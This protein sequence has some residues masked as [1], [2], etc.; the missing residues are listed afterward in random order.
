MKYLAPFLFLILISCG[1]P[2][3]LETKRGINYEKSKDLT[4]VLDKATIESKIVFVDI[5]T[6][7]CLPCKEMDKYVFEDEPTA[8]FMNS[9]FVN[10]KVNAEK[11]EGPDLNI[12]YG[13]SAYP[14]LLFLDVKGRVLEKYEGSMSVSAFNSWAEGVLR[15]NGQ[16]IVN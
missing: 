4:S 1:S 7:W 10:Y 5:Y 13:V 12:I 11:G 16:E 3:D 2:Q 15:D 6:D 14:T 9:N 8:D